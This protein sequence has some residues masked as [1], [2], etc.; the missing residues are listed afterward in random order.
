[1]H[2][3]QVGRNHL[4]LRADFTTGHGRRR[5]SNR[6][7]PRA[8][9]AKTVRRRI[10]IAFFYRDAVSRNADFAGEDLRERRRMPLPL[11]NRAKPRNGRTRRVNTDLAA[12]EHAH[13]EDVAVLDGTGTDDL[14]EEGQT[15][16]H[17]LAGFAALERLDPF[18]LFGPQP[19]VVHGLQRFVPSRVIVAA[20][21]F[22]A[23]SRLIR[24]LLLLDEVD[25]AQ[26]RGIHVQLNRQNLDHPLDEIHRFGHPE[27]TAI[28]HAAGG[29]VGIDTVHTQIGDR[30]VV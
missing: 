3:Q 7:R 17:Q 20:V 15:D 4:R 29:L 14:G 1:M 10:G 24:E 2:F 21:V 27:R 8:I 5:P 16:A 25:P 18:G 30:D 6:S 22:P 23:E 13:P 26:F 11:G 28:G 12:V 9:G 19:L